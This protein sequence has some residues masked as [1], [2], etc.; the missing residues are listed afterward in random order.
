MYSLRTRPVHLRSYRSTVYA[1]C[2]GVEDTEARRVGRPKMSMF[3]SASTCGAKRPREDLEN[4]PDFNMH[5]A[6]TAACS[7]SM[8]SFLGMVTFARLGITSMV[9]TL[10][11]ASALAALKV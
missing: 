5:A 1:S 2:T 6:V 8:E 9:V 7:G 4:A 3:V 11:A 10:V